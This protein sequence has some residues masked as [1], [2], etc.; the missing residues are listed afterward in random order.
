MSELD[1]GE[2]LPNERM[3]QQALAGDVTQIH[4][5]HQYADAGD[6]FD[7]DG[8]TFE[9][10][11]VTERTLGDLTDEDA[12]AEGMDDLEGYRRLLERAHDNFE[13]DDDSEVV[14]HRFER[15]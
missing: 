13:W 4:R 2:L 15:Q 1:P 11:D 6:T 14:R 8:E 5:G 9:L 3:Q 10:T 7:I 12:Q